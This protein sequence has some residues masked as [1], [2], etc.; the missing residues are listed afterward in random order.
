MEK[1]LAFAE[2]PEIDHRICQGF[3]TVGELFLHA[4]GSHSIVVLFTNLNQ[5][6]Q[7]DDYIA[8]LSVC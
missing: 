6:Q 4:W 3:D 2:I 7:E 5:F 8:R 1:P